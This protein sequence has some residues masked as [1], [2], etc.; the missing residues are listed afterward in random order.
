MMIKKRQASQTL[1]LALM[2]MSSSG[3]AL[4]DGE[5]SLKTLHGTYVFTASGFTI[6]AGVP[7]AKAI[8][9]VIDFK[10]DGTLSVPGATRSVNGAVL[11]TLP[12]TTGKYTIETE[13]SATI[14]FDGG[15]SFDA[16]VSPQGG[17]GWV[18]QTN[19]DNVFAGTI[20]I[21]VKPEGSCSNDTLKGAYGLILSGTR[22]AQSVPAGQP[23]FVGQLEQVY[24]SVVQ[25]FDG[26]G[27]FTQ[28]D[29]VKGAISGITPD[30]PGKGTYTVGADCSLTQQVNP[31]PGIFIV[32]KGV[33]V[34]GGKEIRTNTITPDTINVNSVGRKVN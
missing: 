5:C 15:P 26:K 21:A 28:V 25:V 1:V 34:D 16:F 14:A 19:S 2:I 4:A 11:K 18:I 24:G 6:V 27:N 32:S 7:Q 13:C 20:E 12:G 8:V 22:P 30:R 17:K 29:N 10:G 3:L 23:G 31:G 9:E 33:I